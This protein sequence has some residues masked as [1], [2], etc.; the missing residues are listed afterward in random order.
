M[1]N[2]IVDLSKLPSTVLSKLPYSIKTH[3]QIYDLNELPFDIQYILQEYLN[4]KSESV[5]YDL[6]LD[7]TP[8]ISEYG[9]FKVIDNLFDLITEYIKNYIQIQ[10]GDYPFDPN[11]GS[12]LKRY[13]QTLD[14]KVQ[15]QLISK[16]IENIVRMLT[17]DIKADIKIL[18]FSTL[19]TSSTGLDVE[20]SFKIRL[21][22]NNSVRDLTMTM[23]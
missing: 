13:I 9:D 14:K 7:A 15:N 3:K 19:K 17:I 20:Y 2:V 11:F 8:E 4:A 10:P 22:V 23:T 12:K 18:D 1:D 5:Y 6:V 21:K 16:E